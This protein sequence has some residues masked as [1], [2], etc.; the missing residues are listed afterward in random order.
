M[1][2]YK[3]ITNILDNHI[4]LLSMLNPRVLPI[5]EMLM[6]DVSDV[7]ELLEKASKKENNR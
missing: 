7:K 4:K 1:N 2:K 5:K 6:K 3:E